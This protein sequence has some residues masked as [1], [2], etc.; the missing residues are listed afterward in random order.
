MIS[1][2]ISLYLMED[3]TEICKLGNIPER[4]HLY[5]MND[6]TNTNKW[7]NFK[8][9]MTTPNEKQLVDILELLEKQIL[10]LDRSLNALIVRQEDDKK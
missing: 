8:K 10:T 4:M 7:R 6:I 2:R 5:M 1:E 3:F 9:R